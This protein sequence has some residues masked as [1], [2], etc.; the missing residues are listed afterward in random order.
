M[1]TILVTSGNIGNPA[2]EELARKGLP[3]RVAVRKIASNP[4]WQSLGTEQVV[5][6]W[7]R[8]DSLGPAFRGGRKF[9]S[10]TPFVENLVELGC[11]A[12]EAARR[13]NVEYIVR[14]SALGAGEDAGI[15][16]GRWHG[17]VDKV[18]ADS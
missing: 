16:M 7:S 15:T 6:D 2:A 18:L 3:V 14:S 12:I 4:L 10:V 8:P 17:K 11:N 9:L 13:A 1:K 5:V